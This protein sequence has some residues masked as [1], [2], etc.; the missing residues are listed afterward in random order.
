[1][2]KIILWGEAARKSLKVGVDAVAN[3]VKGTLGP[4]GRNV[5]FDRGYGGPTV[6]NDGVSIAR[7]VTLEDPIEN[8]GANLIKETAQKTNDVAGDGTTTSLVLAQAIITEGMKRIDVGINAI[9]LRNGITKAAGIAVA[10]LKKMAKPIK[11]DAETIQVATISAESPEIGKII[12]DTIA[13]LGQDAVITVEESPITGVISEVS[14]GMEFDKGYISPYMMTDPARMEAECKNVSI[15]VTDQTIGAIQD[16]VPF[17]EAFMNT[18]KRELVIIAEDIVG[19]S[20]HTMVVNKMR[21]SITILGIKAPGFGLR[22][23]D[24]LQDIATVTGAT[25]VASDLGMTFD[26]V[27]LDMLGS[28][29]RV[30][31]TKDKTTIIGGRGSKESIDARIAVARKEIS[32][33]ESKH[34]ILKVEERIAKLSGGVAIIKVGAPTEAE[35]KYLKLKVEDAVSAVKSALEEGIV[36]GGGTA[37][38]NASKA[39]LEAKDASLTLDEAI[40]FAIL[41]SALEAPLL[42]IAHNA[43]KGDG[44][45]VVDRVKGALEVSSLAGYDALNDQYV[46]DMIKE[47]IVDPVKVTRSAIENASS[48][49]GIFLTM[50]TAIA[51]RREEVVK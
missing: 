29:D 28:A 3:S 37:L 32:G 25:L 23:K 34:D 31:S 15:L 33:L 1:M 21:G 7:E 44:S 35:A 16:L 18:G 51:T 40:G 4:K 49:A 36:C 27:T 20:L 17:L 12:A 9:G 41:A 45:I 46:T 6:T 39:I 24:Y 14:Q 50:D 38:L 13:K 5:A 42:N 10:A 11:S 22:K 48:T 8:M 47:G 26:K 43:G 30:V 19:E 2:A